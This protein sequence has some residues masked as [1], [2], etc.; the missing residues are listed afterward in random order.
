[1]KGKIK[2]KFKILSFLDI[3]LDRGVWKYV[4]LIA[5]LNGTGESCSIKF[6]VT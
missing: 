1:M 2:R 6:L 3:E 4:T 5:N